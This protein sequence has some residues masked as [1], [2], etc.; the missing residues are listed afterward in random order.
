LFTSEELHLLPTRSQ[1]ISALRSGDLLSD[2]VIE[3]A[4][5]TSIFNLPHADRMC[6]AIVGIQKFSTSA[7]SNTEGGNYRIDN[8]EWKNGTRSDLVL[9]P[10]SF[11]T[12]LRPIIIEFQKTVDA[13]FMK[14]AVNYCL[15]ASQRYGI[16]PILFIICIVRNNI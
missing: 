8:C 11:D 14:R 6:K 15:Q 16:D 7:I 12:G 13:K 2:L 5:S 9:A 3:P 1:I 10:T 4:F